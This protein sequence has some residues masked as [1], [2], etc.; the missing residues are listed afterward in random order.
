MSALKKKD[1]IPLSIN[2]LKLQRY[3]FKFLNCEEVVFLEFLIVKGV[4][5][6]YKPFYH[7]SETIFNET[8]IRKHSLN[9]II[10]KFE[11]LGYISIEVKGMPKVKYFTVHYP[12]I[13]KDVEQIYQLTEN[14]KPLYDFRK[15]LAE[16]YQPLIE[17][18]QEKYINKNKE[19]NNEKEKKRAES[20]AEARDFKYFSDSLSILKTKLNISD[21]K[22]HID[23][24]SI[25]NALK[26]YEADELI[27][28][29]ENFYVN[30]RFKKISDF[31]KPDPM[32]PDKI[33]FIEKEKATENRYFESFLVSLEDTYN[34][35]IEIYNDSLPY[36]KSR[37]KTK[38]V[39]NHDIKEKIKAALAD[40]GEIAVKHAFTAYSDAV[41][42]EFIRPQ[43]FM[44]YFLSKKN[45]EFSVIDTFLNHYNMNYCYG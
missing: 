30:K 21:V 4:S 25:I 42:R 38:L 20:E 5:F 2:I 34:E 17:T 35:R 23:D 3:N 44:P 8:G 9:T 14:G 41:L 28:H 32:F 16:Y 22:F 39:L 29:L 27:D 24:I 45:G 31:F 40:K 33:D 37:P 13:Y 6:K 19:E 12:A 10:K 11:T 36:H 26:T 1:T 43:K 15:L 18:Y 7:S